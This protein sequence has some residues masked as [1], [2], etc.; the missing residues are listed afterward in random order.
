MAKRRQIKWRA[1][2]KRSIGEKTWFSCICL[3]MVRREGVGVFAS[4]ISKN[5]QY[6]FSAQLWLVSHFC[7]H[8]PLFVRHSH[9]NWIS[10]N[11]IFGCY[12]FKGDLVRIFASSSNLEQTHRTR[13][14]HHVMNITHFQHYIQSISKV[15][16]KANCGKINE[17]FY[18]SE[19]I[20]MGP[21]K[22]Q[23]TVTLPKYQNKRFSA[24][25]RDPQLAKWGAAKTAVIQL[26]K[27]ANAF[28]PVKHNELYQH[29]KDL[30]QT[31]IKWNKVE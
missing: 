9:W 27:Q 19:P 7:W 31:G 25:S 5:A 20:A 16:F 29:F 28:I 24:V 12:N 8:L 4:F 1:K 15:H 13:E 17:N 26:K 21:G 10:T 30:Q 2:V 14:I 11:S 18:F 3:A 6:L 22:V 23:V